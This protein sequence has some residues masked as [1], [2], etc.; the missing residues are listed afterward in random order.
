M[1]TGGSGSAVFN[2]AVSYDYGT[3]DKS[4]DS[5]KPPVFN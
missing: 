5:S 1:S 4:S 2:V 3:D